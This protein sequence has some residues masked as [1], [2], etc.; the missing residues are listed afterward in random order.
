MTDILHDSSRSRKYLPYS[1]LANN[2][3][4]DEE[5]VNAIYKYTDRLS[6]IS[7]ANLIIDTHKL[8]CRQQATLKSTASN[9]GNVLIFLN[10]PLATW[11][12]CMIW[13]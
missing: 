11:G 4:T 6:R 12:T 2:N 3:S 5:D 1:W 7:V 8:N 9:E 13:V 10:P